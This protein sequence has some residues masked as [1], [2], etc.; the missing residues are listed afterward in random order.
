MH[1]AAGKLL[2]RECALYHGCKV[3]HA[4][5]TKGYKLPAKFVIHVAPPAQENPAKLKSCYVN[6]LDLMVRMGLRTLGLTCVGVGRGKSPFD[7]SSHL[8]LETVRGWLSIPEN[9]NAVDR[10]IFVCYTATEYRTYSD[11]L[12]FYFPLPH[13]KHEGANSHCSPAKQ[14]AI[15]CA[16]GTH[17]AS[18]RRQANKRLPKHT[19]L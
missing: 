16:D 11:L 1:N 13:T 7:K 9:R 10:I 4:R 15:V 14:P 3:G 8:A 19:Q 2:L 17:R 18:S 5:I 12:H 6:S